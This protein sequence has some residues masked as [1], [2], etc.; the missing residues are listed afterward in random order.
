M[1]KLSHSYRLKRLPGSGSLVTTS[2]SSNLGPAPSPSEQVSLMS[3]LAAS[4]DEADI[5]RVMPDDDVVPGALSF[6]YRGVSS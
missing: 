6:W 4:M 2:S 1:A 3:V 5:C